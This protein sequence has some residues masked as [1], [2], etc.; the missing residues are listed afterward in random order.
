M[1]CLI[2]YV[3]PYYGCDAPTPLSGMYL[4][5]LPGIEFA[6][7]EQIANAD[8]ITWQGVWNDLQ[9]TAKD[10]FREDII[11]EFGKRYLLRQITQSVD[12]GKNLTGFNNVPA[13]SPNQR[14][15]LLET[16][17]TASQ[18]AGSNM[19]NI[20]IQ[21]L[22]FFNDD[23]TTFQIEVYDG[24][25]WELLDTFTPTSV[26]VNGW[27]SFWVDKGY[28]A[29]KLY[30][31][32][33]GDMTNFANLNIANF[34]LNNFGGYMWGFNNPYSYLYFNFGSCGI[35]S[36]LQGT[37]FDPTSNQFINGADTFGLSIVFSTKCTWDAVVCKNK[38]HF[39]SA[40]QHCLAIELLN[41][42]I[43]TSRL[44][45]WVTIDKKSAQELQ[46]LFSLKYRGGV[47]DGLSYVGKLQNAVTSIQPNDNDGCILA[48]DY[49]IWRETTT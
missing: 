3:A 7:I 45:K 14:G 16:R 36:R 24:Q 26:V 6:N 1:D 42:R 34:N 41:Y 20:Y 32:V 4:S 9:A 25:S 18:C 11:E 8:Q 31:L 49:T 37:Y 21:E 23:A 30:I 35:Q 5:Q 29:D 12:L 39:A 19:N 48:N 2:D 27:N 22:N 38:K 10:T 28:T 40:W 15:I 33:T 46:K 13:L 47:M 17:D 44:N 43:N